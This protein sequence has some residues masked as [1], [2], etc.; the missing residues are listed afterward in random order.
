MGHGVWKAVVDV[1]C[2]L[3]RIVEDSTTRC[4]SLT[5]QR[6]VKFS[7]TR[8]RLHGTSTTAFHTRC[9]RNFVYGIPVHFKA[10]IS[11]VSLF[12]SVITVQTLAESSNGSWL[13]AE[14]PGLQ[15]QPNRSIPD[16]DAGNE[17]GEFGDA[18]WSI[19][20]LHDKPTQ[21]AN[22]GQ[23]SV[24]T[25]SEHRGVNVTT[26]QWNHNPSTKTTN[27]HSLVVYISLL[28]GNTSAAF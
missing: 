5:L 20:D 24:Q 18:S 22:S 8:C 11:I 4:R 23:S 19:A 21:P 13:S 17:A 7:T 9:I 6:V 12:S 15:Q 16:A 26:A 25:A 27:R 1:P 28:A 3:Q 10:S 14:L 2:N